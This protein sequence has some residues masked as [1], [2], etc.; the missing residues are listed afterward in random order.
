MHQTHANTWS[1]IAEALFS[2]KMLN[3]EDVFEENKNIN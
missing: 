3:K 1:P 2:K